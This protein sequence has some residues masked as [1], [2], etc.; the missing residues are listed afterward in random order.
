M[1]IGG[2]VFLGFICVL[3]KQS[4]ERPAFRPKD[5]FQLGK[6]MAKPARVTLRV[7]TLK[8]TRLELTLSDGMGWCFCCFF[9]EELL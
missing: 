9:V 5:A 3:Q 7:N 2:P 6:A 4:G 8:T 1:V